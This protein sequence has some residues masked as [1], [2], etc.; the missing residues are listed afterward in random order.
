MN[1][2]LFDDD[3]RLYDIVS[4]NMLV[5][6]LT[7]DNF[8]SLSPELL[9]K[10]MVMYKEPQTFIQINGMTTAVPIISTGK[11]ESDTL[12]HEIVS[13]FS[14]HGFEPYQGASYDQLTHTEEVYQGIFLSFLHPCTEGPS[15]DFKWPLLTAAL[16][17]VIIVYV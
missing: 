8:C 17:I 9:A 11:E 3:G 13:L 14:N 2:G 15:V 5:V 7:D 10:Y 4:G 1:R 12:A 6:G 16:W